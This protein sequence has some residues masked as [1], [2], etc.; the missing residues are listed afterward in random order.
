MSDS[1]FITIGNG[2]AIP[3]DRIPEL[4]FDDFRDAIIR[5]TA[6]GQRIS[7]LFGD[8]SPTSSNVDLY[9]VLADAAQSLLRVAKAR[10]RRL[11]I[12]DSRLPAGSFV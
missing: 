11:S 5:A 2:E 1:R 7:S 9:V 6:A 12:A 8:A 3:R 10:R 4:S